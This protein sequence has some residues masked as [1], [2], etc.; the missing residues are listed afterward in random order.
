MRQDILHVSETEMETRAAELAAQIHAPYAL[1]LQGDLG[2][3]KSSFARALIRSLSHDKNLIVPSPT[4]TM[5]QLYDTPRGSVYHFDLYRLTASEQVYD[6]GWEEALDHIVIVEWPER[7]ETL[8][9]PHAITLHFENGDDALHR[10][11]KGWPL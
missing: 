2:M 10:R 9:P 4:F 8:T 1:M 11:I 5:L 3:G 7:L 6:L